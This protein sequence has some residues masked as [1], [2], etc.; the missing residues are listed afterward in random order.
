MT[1]LLTFA[2]LLLVPAVACLVG[3]APACAWVSTGVGSGHGLGPG[4]RSGTLPLPA[5]PLP[6]LVSLLF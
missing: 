2:L 6:P 1:R 3:T 5:L 4:R